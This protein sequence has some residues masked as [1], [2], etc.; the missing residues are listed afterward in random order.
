MSGTNLGPVK[1]IG[2]LVEDIDAAVNAWMDHMGV[3]PWFVIKNIRLDCVYKGEPAQPL[4]DIALAY[5][6]DVQIELIQQKNDAPSPYRKFFEEKRMGVHH[7]AHLC[8][9]INED[10][11]RAVA[12]GLEVVCDINMFDGSRYVY[13]QNPALGNEVF[14]EFIENTDMMKEMFTSG[15]ETAKNWDGNRDITVMDLAQS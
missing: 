7:L 3:G 10:V 13:A 4:I 12:Q 2:Y 6:G 14:V 8:D 5:N 9:N 11:D 15:I 1:Q